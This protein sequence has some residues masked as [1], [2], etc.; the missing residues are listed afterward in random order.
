MADNIT[1][2]VTGGTRG[3]GR[4]VAAEF[5]RRGVRVVVVARDRERGEQA[6]AE[7]GNGAELVTGDLSLLSDVRAVA[8]RLLE[9][10]DRIDV[11]VHNAGVW[12][13]RLVRTADKLE[14]SFTVNHL[15]PFL[16][17]HL[18]EERLVA[19]RTRIVQLTAGLYAKGQLDLRRTPIGADFHRVRT[20]ATTKLANLLTVPLFAR[21]WEDTGIRI[22]A[23]HPGVV[24]TAL[25]AGGG[26]RGLVLKGIKR[27]WAPPEIAALPVVR[28]TFAPADG[29]SGRYFDC[30]RPVDLA[31]VATDEGLAQVVWE[32]AVDLTDLGPSAAPPPL[33]DPVAP[34]TPPEAPEH[35]E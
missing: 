21:R 1:A 7:L 10:C 25:G 3:I 9:R 35:E 19:D 13:T 18:L 11:L 32:Q 20:Y 15:A 33:P 29:P 5:A 2:V 16:L 28:L 17:N 34:V 27:A 4:A 14:E 24:N 23:I 26:L 6:V 30:E 8:D 31:P 12:P 22:D